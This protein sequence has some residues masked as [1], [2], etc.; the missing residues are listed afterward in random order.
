MSRTS[1]AACQFSA[2]SNS[3]IFYKR[4][5]CHVV[6]IPSLMDF[7]CHLGP[8]WSQ[9]TDL[10]CPGTMPDPQALRLCMASIQPRL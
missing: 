2:T 7:P 8:S 10:S 4:L 1:Q 9:V 5:W 6:P 3:L